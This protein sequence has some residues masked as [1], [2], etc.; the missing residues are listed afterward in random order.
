MKIKRICRVYYKRTVKE[1]SLNRR[2][3]KKGPW[4]IRKEE[5]SN[6][7]VDKYNKFSSL[8]FLKLYLIVGPKVIMLSYMKSESRGNIQT[9]ISYTEEGKRM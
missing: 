4:S 5:H 9:I 6:K 8:D 2:K 7:N 1:N 3:Q